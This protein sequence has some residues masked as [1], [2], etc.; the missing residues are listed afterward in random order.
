M[1][2]KKSL[3]K[4]RNMEVFC[5]QTF[6]HGTNREWGTMFFN[7]EI[8]QRHDANHAEITNP[9][10]I[11]EIVPEIEEFY[12]SKHI[13]IRI[14]YYDPS[15]DSSLKNTLREN[16]FTCIENNNS[17]IFMKLEKKIE[18]DEIL[19]A[20]DRY[21]VSFCPA[22]ITESQI[23]KDVESVI[24]SDWGYQNIVSNNNY[25]YFILYDAGVPVSVLSFF[26]YEPYL[27]A[28]LDD[29][30]TI[31]E[32]RNKGYSTFLLKFACNWVQNNDFT[33]YLFVHSNNVYAKKT[34]E[35]VGFTEIFSCKDV[36]WIKES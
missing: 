29:V 25:Y 24:H 30:V 19:S 28:R 31:P 12:R 21:R 27:L 3:E 6:S 17:V 5:F 10:H 8:L 26:L 22:I 23:V 15:N 32:Y 1:V 36:Y 34:Y 9:I 14:N 33:P 16:N 18:F 35:R 20:P 2:D 4:F 11:H 7:K 13:P